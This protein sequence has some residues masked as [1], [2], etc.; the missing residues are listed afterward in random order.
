MTW[1]SFFCFLSFSEWG[2]QLI[3]AAREEDMKAPRGFADLSRKPLGIQLS[4]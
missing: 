3:A 4:H 1:L 2:H